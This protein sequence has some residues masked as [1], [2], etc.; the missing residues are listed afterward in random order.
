MSR[1]TRL[2]VILAKIETTY[3]TDAVP[4][5]ADNALL[6]SEPTLSHNYNNV[7]RDNIKSFL[8]AD[9]ELVGTRSVTM[10]FRVEISGSGTAGTAPAWGPLLRACAMAQTITAGQRVEYNPISAAF[11]SL[12]IYYH[13]DGVLHK[14]TGCRGTVE[15]M[16]EEGSIPR[17][18]FSF[19]G[20][21][22]GP[23]AI[24]NPTQTLTAW[25]TPQVV[26]TAN[27]AAVKLG[28]TYSAGALSGGTDFCT[29]GLMLNLGNEVTFS[30]MLGPCTRVDIQNRAA[31]GSL[32][33]DLD[34]AGE[35]TQYS[36]VN[37]NT[38][39]SVG[40]LHGTGAGNRVLV[41]AP[42]VQRINP[43]QADFNG[44]IQIGM[45]LRLTPVSG[46][47]ELRIVAL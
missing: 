16:L 12:T 28:S 37:A 1:L 13:R 8:G 29:R 4:T 40:L 31:T 20:L 6:V 5:G 44:R 47:D 33:L 25:R 41:F 17:M 34:A 36:A 2:T 22:A 21:D 38:L 46:N 27:S 32:Q 7:A 15:F 43:T 19:T 30:S 24:A 45:D 11:E 39:T 14:A 23:V 10:G 35:V 18:L 26:T 9:E 3:G 42:A